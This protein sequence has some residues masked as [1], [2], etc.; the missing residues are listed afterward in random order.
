MNKILVNKVTFFL[1]IIVFTLL[2]V[3]TSINF[4]YFFNESS[5]VEK[6]NTHIET[7]LNQMSIDN[8]ISIEELELPEIKNNIVSEPNLIAI[9]PVIKVSQKKIKKIDMIIPINPK[10][11]Y[12][13]NN[14]N[15][16]KLKITK[17]KLLKNTS[18]G[19]K[20]NNHNLTLE[21]INYNNLKN[22]TFFQST[23]NK[24]KRH[25]INLGQTLLNKNRNYEVEFLWPLNNAS[26]NKIYKILN[27][28]LLS[29]TVLM[30]SDNKIFGLKGIITT[31][32]IHNKF[33]NIIRMPTNVYS[34]LEKKNISIIKQKYFGN[35]KAR[36]LRLFR[37]NVDAF[38][39]GYYLKLALDKG[40]KIKKIKGNYT[41]INNELYLDKLMINLKPFKNIISLSSIA[42]SCNI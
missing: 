17:I 5:S 14:I 23:N 22:N 4:F 2:F 28:C 8:P 31:N 12:N 27:Q 33:S 13:T 1:N 35:N 34:S 11:T 36:H 10:K 41:I 9:D 15:N 3:F 21:P 40:L 39:L 37:K 42:K 38:I 7:K 24:D 20:K 29:E 30:G 26:H 16:E 32:E 6:I 18:K 25:L 19:Y